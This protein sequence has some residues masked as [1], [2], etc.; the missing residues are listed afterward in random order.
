MLSIL[1]LAAAQNIALPPID[2]TTLFA[3]IVEAQAARPA[4]LGKPITSFRTRLNLRERG[5]HPSEVLID[6]SY[7]TQKGGVVE[8]LVDDAE[9]GIRLHKGFDGRHFWMTGEDDERVLLMGHEFTQDRDEIDQLLTLCQDLLLLLDLSRLQNSAKEIHATATTD[10]TLLAG[11]FPKDDTLWR[12]RIHLKGESRLPVVLEI[13][14]PLPLPVS[15]AKPE[16]ENLEKEKPKTVKEPKAQAHLFRLNRWHDFDG[17]IIPR[18]I[19]EYPSLSE[20][21]PSRIIE[22]RLLEWKAQAD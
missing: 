16:S 19:E 21:Y 6:L 13:L 2:A 5:E 8:M 9:R 3:E 17:R 12:F 22:L 11:L 1:L 14:P 18:I 15:D 4:V 7:Q 20:L 10:G